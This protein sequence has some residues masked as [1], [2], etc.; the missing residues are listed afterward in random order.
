MTE[1]PS[2]QTSPAPMAEF[3]N[4]DVVFGKHSAQALA[5][6][7]AGKT[8]QEILDATG[9]VLGAADCSAHGIVRFG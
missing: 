9:A 7:D 6:L 4:V 5:L 3:R 2:P 1:G 8:R